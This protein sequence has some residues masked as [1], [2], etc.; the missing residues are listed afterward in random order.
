MLLVVQ[1][2]FPH[3][4]HETHPLHHRFLLRARRPCRAR[5]RAHEGDLVGLDLEQVVEEAKVCA[6]Y[7]T[8][9]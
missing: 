2:H 7:T 5:R 3:H 9:T 1:F 8:A 4:F 6:F